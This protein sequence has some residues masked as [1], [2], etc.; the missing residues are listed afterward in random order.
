MFRVYPSTVGTDREI[1]CTLLINTYSFAGTD[2]TAAAIRSILLWVITRPDV[3]SK[4]HSELTIAKHEE[5]LSTPVKD[6]E[7][8]LLPYLQACIKEGI[9]ICPP[10]VNPSFKVVPKGGDEIGGYYV[11]EGI[12]IGI[13]ALGLVRNH[14]IWGPD[15]DF[16]QPDRWLKPS[17]EMKAMKSTWDMLFGQGSSHC[18]GKDIALMQIGVIVVEVSKCLHLDYSDR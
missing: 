16:F 9:R 14:K 4:I 15:A 18:L 12:E 2:T 13:S 7:A 17:T 8:R 6:K 3:L 11:P 1:Y 10:V 5:R